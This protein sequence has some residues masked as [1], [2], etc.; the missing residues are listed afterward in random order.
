MKVQ[1]SAVLG[2]FKVK[3]IISQWQVNAGSCIRLLYGVNQ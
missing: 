1:Y 2:V 3:K